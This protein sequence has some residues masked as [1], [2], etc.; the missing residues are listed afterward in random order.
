MLSFQP[1]T[2]R[3]AKLRIPTSCR[4]ACIAVVKSGTH[5]YELKCVSAL[6]FWLRVREPVAQI[7]INVRAHVN[8]IN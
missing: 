2:Q 3:K 5:P 1:S 7:I 4:T 6:Y 8:E